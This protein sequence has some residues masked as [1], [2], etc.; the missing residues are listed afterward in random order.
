LVIGAGIFRAA[1]IEDAADDA[2]GHFEHAVLLVHAFE[3]LA[4]HAV[5][6]LPLLVHDVVV[7][8]QVFARF[9]VLRFNRLLRTFN[10]LGDHLR[11]DGHAFFHAQPFQQR[12]DP[13][14]GEDAHEIVFER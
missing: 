3:Q 10:P 11:L 9:E 1:H 7:F 14:L 6:G 8:E 12:G 4:A 5:N 13:L 2:L